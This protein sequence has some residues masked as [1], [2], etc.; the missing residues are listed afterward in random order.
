MSA[1][2]ARRRTLCRQKLREKGKNRR[3]SM[4]AESATKLEKFGARHVSG[5]VLKLRKGGARSENV[6]VWGAHAYPMPLYNMSEMGV[7][8]LKSCRGSLL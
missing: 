2:R 3:K 6:R 5:T 4:L 8:G 1:F 7:D